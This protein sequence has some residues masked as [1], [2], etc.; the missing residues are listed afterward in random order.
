MVLELREKPILIG[1][2]SRLNGNL[3]YGD[4]VCGFVLQNMRD[5]TKILVV[6][7]L[8]MCVLC[9]KKNLLIITLFGYNNYDDFYQI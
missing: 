6:K 9:C 8:Y 5:N 2:Y 1:T 7:N 4:T 3:G